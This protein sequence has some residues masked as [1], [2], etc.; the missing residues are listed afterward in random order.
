[1]KIIAQCVGCKTKREI[2]E[3]ESD[4]LSSDHS[5]PMCDKCFMPMVAVSAEEDRFEKV[6][7]KK[8]Q[9]GGR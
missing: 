8:I 5:V 7:W 1:M 4:R 9:R 3:A 2:D 6:G